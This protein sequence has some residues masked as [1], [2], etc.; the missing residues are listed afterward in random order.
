MMEREAARVNSAK[1]TN[2]GYPLNTMHIH[3]SAGALI[4]FALAFIIGAGLLVVGLTTGRMAVPWSNPAKF[5]GWGDP[6]NFLGSLVAWIVLAVVSL[7]GMR[8]ARRRLRR[9]WRRA[10]RVRARSKADI[11]RVSTT[12]GKHTLAQ[13]QR[14]WTA[15]RWAVAERLRAFADQRVYWRNPVSALLDHARSHQLLET[16]LN[17][18]GV[19]V[20]EQAELMNSPL[21]IAQGG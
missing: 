11:W 18:P 5:V 12:R 8:W 6:A 16:P 17:R 15:S 2:G 9:D 7:R 19:N 14:A 10:I 21:S 20:R 1:W 13:R 4:V 3:R